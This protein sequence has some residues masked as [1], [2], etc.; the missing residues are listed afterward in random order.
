[1]FHK[2]LSIMLKTRIE[3]DK[4]EA[5]KLDQLMSVSHMRAVVV[6]Q[7]LE[8]RVAEARVEFDA[9]LSN[10]G[11]NYNPAEIARAKK[12][13]NSLVDY[14]NETKAQVDSDFEGYKPNTLEK[15]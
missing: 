14:Y 2:F 5:K 6:L 12:E 3:N 13:Y 1:M 4:S 11:N 10:F 9:Q 15:L 8:K 7:E